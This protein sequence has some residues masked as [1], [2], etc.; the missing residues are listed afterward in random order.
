MDLQRINLECEE[1]LT[2]NLQIILS[3][4]HEII[5]FIQLG[6]T[7]ISTSINQVR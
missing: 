5:L 3:Y 1:R 4:V 2:A 7:L 6:L